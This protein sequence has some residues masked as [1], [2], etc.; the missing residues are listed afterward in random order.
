MSRAS[1]DPS[2]FAG[3]VVFTRGQVVD[4]TTVVSG[5]SIVGDGQSPP[6]R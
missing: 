1:I 5:A 6:T 3:I 2:F 4:K